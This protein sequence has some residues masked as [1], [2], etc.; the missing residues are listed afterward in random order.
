M[1]TLIL[2]AALMF[3]IAAIVLGMVVHLRYPHT[4]HKKT[5]Y[6]LAI[7]FSVIAMSVN[8][9]KYW[10]VY[11][12]YEFLDAIRT[13]GIGLFD[14]LFNNKLRI[15]GADY[16]SLFAYNLIRYAVVVLGNNR[17][18]P[19]IMTLV[20]YAVW[21]YI[22]IDWAE[23]HQMSGND[24]VVSMMLSGVLMPFIYV[25]SGLRNT[26]AAAIAA[27]AIYN[28]LYK[29]HSIRE[30]IVL[31]FAAFTI[32]FSMIY[33]IVVYLLVKFCSIKAA[34]IILFVWTN[35][36]PSIAAL[37][38]NSSYEILRK[39]ASSFR[40]YTGERTFGINYY[41]F[42]ACVVLA[43]LAISLLLNRKIAPEDE[44]NNLEKFIKL[45]VMNA[46][47]NVGYTQL[48]L[49]P[50]YTLGAMSTPVLFFM[51]GCR[52]SGV[53]TQ[54]MVA[55]LSVFIGLAFVLRVS[56]PEYLVITYC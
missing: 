6:I 32:H 28:N 10:D 25:N 56:L 46:L 41:L 33:V 50:L 36:I 53:K 52:Q 24:I 20:T 7:S 34:T 51:Y 29:K 31:F 3:S 13:S 19:F 15:G 43:A 48:V 4:V 23:K 55:V 30:L 5:L 37:F 44:N 14:F 22:T 8:P 9:T 16:G 27:L 47:F 18:L 42:G 40:I 35:V 1:E 49:R 12:Q 2:N 26:T 39:M 45:M 38:R 11:R 54:Q 17:I 21:S